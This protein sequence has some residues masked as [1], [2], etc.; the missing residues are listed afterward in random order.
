MTPPSDMF[1]DLQSA[2][3]QAGAAMGVANTVVDVFTAPAMV[4]TNATEE[5]ATGTEDA[6]DAELNGIA[7]TGSTGQALL[8]RATG[9]IMNPNMELLFKKPQLR[10]FNFRFKLWWSTN[11]IK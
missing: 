3:K 8:T 10:P 2:L 11:G 4:S 9:N 7:A 1:N 5:S 6:F